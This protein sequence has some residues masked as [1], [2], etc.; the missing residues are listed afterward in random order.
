MWW[1]MKR[2]SAIP[3][4]PPPVLAERLADAAD[5]VVV[6]DFFRGDGARGRRSGAAIALLRERGFAAWA[7]P[8]YAAEAVAAF[9]G[10]LGAE[11]VV[12]SEAGFNDLAWLGA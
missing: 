5:R 7:E 3:P 10:V 2:C 6:D 1:G 12:E 9:R 11:R 8:G 4:R